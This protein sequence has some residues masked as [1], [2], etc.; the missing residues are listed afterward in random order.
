MISPSNLALNYNTEQ[1]I[2]LV[3]NI[4]DEERLFLLDLLSNPDESNLIMFKQ[5]VETKI[6][7]NHNLQTK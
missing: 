4:T 7:G 1:L 2:E 6:N 5:I 3:N